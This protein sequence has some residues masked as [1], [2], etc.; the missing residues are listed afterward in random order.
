M[1]SIFLTEMDP[2]AGA[3]NPSNACVPSKVMNWHGCDGK[4][5]VWYNGCCRRRNSRC[6]ARGYLGQRRENPKYGVCLQIEGKGKWET[7]NAPVKKSTPASKPAPPAEASWC[8][9]YKLPAQFCTPMGMAVLAG[10]GLLLVVMLLK[11]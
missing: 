6:G 9:Q 2:F 1:S 4:S 8:E 5:T 7:R 3:A 10:G 11:K